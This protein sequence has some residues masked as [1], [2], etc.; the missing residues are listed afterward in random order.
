MPRPLLPPPKRPGVQ[1]YIPHAAGCGVPWD[2]FE[3][4]LVPYPRDEADVSLESARIAPTATP[5]PS[6]GVDR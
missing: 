2:V 5:A 1:D 6:R 4:E 3:D